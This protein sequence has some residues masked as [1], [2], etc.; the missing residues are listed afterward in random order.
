MICLEHPDFQNHPAAAAR[1]RYSY[2]PAGPITLPEVSIV[3]PFFD[4]GEI[5]RETATSVLG[6]SLQNFE[7]IIVDDQ[8]TDP[9]SCE[10]LEHYAA[11]DP[12][13]RIVRTAQRSGPGAARNLGVSH[14]K[15]DYIAFIDSDDLYEPTAIEKWRCFL[16]TH[17]GYSFVKGY[18]VGFGADEYLWR[19]GFHSRERFLE[20]NMVQTSSM[21]RRKVY[22]SVGGMCE[23]N[24]FGME[25][26][27]FWLKCANAGHWG[28]TIPEFL[29]WYRR[30]SNHGDAW[31]QWD[32]GN[33]QDQFLR[34][35][36]AKYP[37]LW[38]GKFP[39]PPTLESPHYHPVPSYLHI[40]NLLERPSGVKRM[41]LI[42]PH[43]A[44]GG[45]DKFNVDLIQ[46]LT[47]R[48]G[49]EITV[50]TTLDGFHEWRDVFEAVAPDCFTLDT[51][52]NL[53][54]YP[55]FLSYLIRSRQIETVLISHS[56]LGYQLLPFLR[57]AAKN[58]CF[59][60]YLHIEE[61]SWKHGGYPRYSLNYQPLLDLTMVTSSHL[62]RWMIER[63]CKDKSVEVCTIN[64]DPDLWDRSRYDAPW[65]RRKYGIAADV[66]VIL[67]V[68]R[69]VEQKQ[70]LVLTNVMKLLRDRGF[71]FVC[72]VVGDGDLRE[73]MRDF[74]EEHTLQEVR[75][76]GSR[77]SE[78]VRELLAISN[79]FFLPSKWE[80]IALSIF[81]AM[82][83]E[84]VPVGADVGG[85]AELVTPD[86]GVLIQRGINEVAEYAEVLS[87]LLLTPSECA[88]MARAGRDRI[89]NHFSLA[90]MGDRLSQLL[91]HATAEKRES[92]R[93]ATAA[94]L[95]IAASAD[96]LEVS[97]LDKLADSL[98]AERRSLWEERRSLRDRLALAEAELRNRPAQSPGYLAPTGA[99]RG[100]ALVE[101]MISEGHQGATG[102]AG[103]PASDGELRWALKE[104]FW[105]NTNGKAGN[106]RFL[107]QIMFPRHIHVKWKNYRLFRQVLRTP[108]ACRI[109][110]QNF[111]PEFYLR[112]NPDLQ[113]RSVNPFLHYLF[114]GFREGRRP[115]QNFDLGD[116]RQSASGDF[117]PLLRFA[118]DAPEAKQ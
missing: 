110:L 23:Q 58:V 21:I 26:W 86:C 50:S 11:M 42:I 19:E 113:Q 6:Q 82:S 94:D 39:P 45:S 83:M 117:N 88:R 47:E 68:G 71:K 41:L 55:S 69:L 27:D 56:S 92:G 22:L 109:V 12:R 95:A 28:D 36:K 4:T 85:Q 40:E 51:F 30:R 32:G 91:E 61:S 101:A 89:L 8:S 111:S 24:R 25:D 103:G 65:I 112:T 35:L 18:Q 118:L 74:V 3:S 73:P 97:R 105:R 115:A 72:L 102:T 2:R 87:R 7:W 1:R 99:D 63:G 16:E 43:L 9:A 48:H 37:D 29:D 17:P 104:L 106:F 59:T 67:F 53:Y 49:Y 114:Y 46:Q 79:V 81:E 34:S 96:I 64:V 13:I 54:D 108:R 38:N 75:F 52:L 20:S 116:H 57:A 98:W 100:T 60:D 70:P 62:K 10:L 80:G 31:P 78:E 14:A 15:A 5:F 90:A 33:N 77:S 107:C 76:L 84:V 44:I 93:A 66:P